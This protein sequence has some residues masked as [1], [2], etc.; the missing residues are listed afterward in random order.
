MLTGKRANPEAEGSTTLQAAG[1]TTV[2]GKRAWSQ[3]AA[4]PLEDRR[5]HSPLEAPKSQ[6]FKQ[7]L[8]EWGPAGTQGPSGDSTDNQIVGSSQRMLTNTRESS[9]HT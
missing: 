3:E 7:K 9:L 4:V 8:G 6:I 1:G 5:G 2:Q